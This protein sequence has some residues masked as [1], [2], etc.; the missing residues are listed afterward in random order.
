VLE[1]ASD[2]PYIIDEQWQEL[3]Q[4]H[5]VVK[6]GKRIYLI[7]DDKASMVEFC[8]EVRDGVEPRKSGFGFALRNGDENL[9]VTGKPAVPAEYRRYLSW[10]K[11]R[12]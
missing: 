5:V 6:W 2:Q 3:W 7:P 11:G 9:L 12:Q 10:S 4:R 1:L 8:H